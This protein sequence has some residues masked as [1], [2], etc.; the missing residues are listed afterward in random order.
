LNH[1]KSWF[2]LVVLVV[3]LSSCTSPVTPT[4]TPLD[5]NAI[6]TAAVKTYEA[7]L[8]QQADSAATNTPEP[9]P[10]ETAITA[11]QAVTPTQEP[12]YTPL[13]TAGNT[14]DHA[15]FV[16]DVTYPDNA[17]VKNGK[18]FTKTW[19]LINAG[20]TTW[21]TDY[22]LIYHSGD[23]MGVQRSAQVPV[24]VPPGATVDISVEMMAPET[25][26]TFQSN[27]ILV[28]AAGQTFG[29]GP[30]ADQ[31]IYAKINVITQAAATSAS[32]PG[33]ATLYLKD[34]S[35]AVDTNYVTRPCPYSFTLTVKFHVI[36]PAKITYRLE[37]MGD[38]VGTPL[39][40]TVNLTPG[41]YKYNHT[42]TLTQAFD[43]DIVL[44][45]TE[46]TSTV[47]ASVP[48]GLTCSKR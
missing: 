47:A 8:T 12:L 20:T 1:K 9:P 22:K 5:P 4:A 7:K 44:R 29:I 24:E 38:Q 25:P 18:D 34:I 3:I 35:L 32:A 21:T 31:P 26:G 19:R 13:P 46:P 41:D 33:I 45:F 14:G 11:T 36:Q 16:K 39:S 17:E 48:I 42:L 2:L 10:A 27:W 23:W 43:G 15:E 40:T 37:V 30:K 6:A 28:N